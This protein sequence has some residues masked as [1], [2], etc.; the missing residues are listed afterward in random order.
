VIFGSNRAGALS[1]RADEAERLAREPWVRSIHF[2]LPVG[3]PV[4]PFTD[5]RRRVGQAMILA[6]TRGELDRRAVNCRKR[7]A[8][9][10]NE[11]L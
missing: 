4:E 3:S 5:G 11:P 2:D 9:T 1:Y 6:D 7:L 8:V 10:A